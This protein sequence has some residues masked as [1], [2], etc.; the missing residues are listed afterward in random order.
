MTTPE[1]SR[2]RAATDP[3]SPR[4][5]R[6]NAVVSNMLEFRKAFGC[7]PGAP[8]AAALSGGARESTSSRTLATIAARARS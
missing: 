4:K 7:K 3:H 5:H 1:T 8:K 6:V 2:L